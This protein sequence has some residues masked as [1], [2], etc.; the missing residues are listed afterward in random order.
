MSKAFTSEEATLE[1]VVPPRAPLP[2]GVPNYV[3]PHGLEL[4]RAERRTLEATRAELERG[5]EEGR[6]A[7]LAA[8]STR[9]GELEQRLASALLVEPGAGQLGVV[10]FGS[11]V[12]VVDDGGQHKTFE[13][14]GVDE[15]DPAR[16]KIAFLAPIAKAL[17]GREVG[18]SVGVQTPGK[19]QD[20]TIVALD[21]APLAGSPEA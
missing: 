11:R 17:L 19:R 12:T 10:R 7:T 16:G 6:G 14:V 2:P 5:P 15:A 20:L 21:R 18:D 1:V 9:L 3:T 8:W 4:L 13:I